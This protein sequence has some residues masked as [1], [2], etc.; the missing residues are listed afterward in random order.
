MVRS[1][2]KLRAHLIHT[3]G[4]P[5]KVPLAEQ[6]LFFDPVKEVLTA[7]H[8]KEHVLLALKP[9]VHA[10]EPPAGAVRG[11]HLNNGNIVV[12]SGT[13]LRANTTRRRRSLLTGT[14]GMG[15]RPRTLP[16][17]PSLSWL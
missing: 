2:I 12:K 16:R 7:S 9:S 17:T 15:S 5:V 11:T 4:V 1:R 8:P 6:V 10:M 13:K 3:N 14:S